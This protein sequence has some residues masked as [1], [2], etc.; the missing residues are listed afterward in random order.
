[1][2]KFASG[3]KDRLQIH[4][5]EGCSCVTRQ[6]KSYV[7]GQGVYLAFSDWS[8]LESGKRLEEF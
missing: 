7:I 3:K 1:M 2:I 8:K 5:C 4:P 6:G